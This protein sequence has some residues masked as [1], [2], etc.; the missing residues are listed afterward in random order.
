MKDTTPTFIKLL[1][2]DYLKSL[3]KEARRVKYL[4]TKDSM[5]VVVRDDET[6]DLVF[7]SIRVRPNI[8][9][10]TFSTLYWKDESLDKFANV[11]HIFYDT[12]TKTNKAS[13]RTCNRK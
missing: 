2:N 6:N 3:V 11:R 8:W 1:G 7:R 5:S 13:R 10:T 12:Y 4:V 9:A